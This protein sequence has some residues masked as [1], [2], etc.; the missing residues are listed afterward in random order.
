MGSIGI[1][2]K[3]MQATS[4]E[5]VVQEQNK[6]C[7][8]CKIK[9]PLGEFWES[10]GTQCKACVKLK[11]WYIRT[12]E[13]QNKKYHERTK[14]LKGQKGL[15]LERCKARATKKGLEFNLEIQ[16]IKIP[17]YCPILG[18]KLQ[19]NNL[20]KKGAKANSPS[21]D[22][23]D[24]SKGYVKGNIMIISNKANSLKSD[25]DVRDLERMIKYMKG[26]KLPRGWW[27]RK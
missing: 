5:I 22:R 15:I 24:N 23:I 21:I 26:E 14:T 18:I 13:K 11:G 10:K 6:I 16:D 25:M 27:T 4:E 9:K 17:K 20:G 8:G 19:F 12:K 1:G 3:K 2:W 7:N